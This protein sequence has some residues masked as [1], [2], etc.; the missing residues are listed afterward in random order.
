MSHKANKQSVVVY[1]E[2]PS[3]QVE[4]VLDVMF[5][6]I[7]KLPYILISDVQKLLQYEGPK[8]NYSHKRECPQEIF[9]PTT[10]SQSDYN[11]FKNTPLF[12]KYKKIP[13]FFEL[14]VKGADLPFDLFRAAFYLLARVE[15][16]QPFSPDSH[17][18]FPASESILV[19]HQYHY[20]PLVDIW[21]KLLFDT[22]QKKYPNLESPLKESSYLPTYDI[23]LPWKYLNRK[24]WRSLAAIGRDLSQFKFQEL[25]ARLSVLAGNKTDPFYTFDWIESLH[26][27]KDIAPLFFIPVGDYGPQDK[28]I[29]PENPAYKSLIQTLEKSNGVGLHLSYR[30]YDSPQ[31]IKIEK[32]RLERI[33]QRAVTKNR[34]HY[35]RFKL[36]DSYRDLIDAGITD[37]YSM[38]FA[39]VAGFRA[40]TAH[41]YPWFDF[42]KNE[43]SKLIIHPFAF[44]DVSLRNYQQIIPGEALQ[45]M[46]AMAEAVQQTG[47]QL[48]SIW[49]NNSL[50]KSPEWNDWTLMYE[51]WI[52]SV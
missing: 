44:M 35:L 8:L 47:G 17:G 19:Q 51:K 5:G 10:T 18:R 22:L 11:E 46:E 25:I 50:E 31:L 34:F 45:T 7:L 33:V 12:F 37:D 3:V 49:H 4:Y 15:E 20:S 38:G 9:I 16:Y 13:A 41:A 48:I 27:P 21:A 1:L 29:D 52:R 43:V 42:E 28:N 23:D 32:E 36:P 40:G 14:R 26:N 6:F 39:Q 2:Y 24:W 30:S